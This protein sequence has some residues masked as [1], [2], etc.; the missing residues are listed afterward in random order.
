MLLPSLVVVVTTPS[1]LLGSTTPPFLG[2]AGADT[3]PSLASHLWLH[4]SGGTGTSLISA[5][6]GVNCSTLLGGS[7]DDTINL[8]GSGVT[9]YPHRCWCW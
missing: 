6:A 5:S 4:R 3:L 1:P 8:T 9:G 7:G 2:G